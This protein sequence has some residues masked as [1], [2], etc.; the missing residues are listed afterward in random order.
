M[1]AA[2]SSTASANRSSSSAEVKKPTLMR[3][4]S[5][6]S[7]VRAIAKTRA[8][9]SASASAGGQPAIRKVTS[10]AIWCV[11]V[12]TVDARDRGEPSRRPRA[13]SPRPRA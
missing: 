8:P 4:A 3:S 2:S 1:C 13:P 9:S 5:R 11:G 12:R 10:V 6:L 7:I